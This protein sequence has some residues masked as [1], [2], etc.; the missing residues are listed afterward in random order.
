MSGLEL[1]LR[2]KLHGNIRI[3]LISL[4][5]SVQ[6]SHIVCKV[7]AVSEHQLKAPCSRHRVDDFDIDI[8]V[9]G[10]KSF[11]M[12]AC[13]TSLSS[14]LSISSRRVLITSMFF[15]Y[16]LMPPLR[17]SPWCS[18]NRVMEDDWRMIRFSSFLA[19]NMPISL[20]W[21]APLSWAPGLYLPSSCLWLPRSA[22][23]NRSFLF[24]FFVSPL[25]IIPYRVDAT[26][27][28]TQWSSIY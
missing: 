22:F 24:L 2:R 27:K 28:G 23:Q 25:G 13:W 4:L 20:F 7:W 9:S 18:H 21:S 12:G 8:R 14:T 6:P 15:N 5:R 17:F 11:T 10:I 16:N 3:Y 26:N 1:Q 19:L